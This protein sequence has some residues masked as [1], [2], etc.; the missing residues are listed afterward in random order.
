[1]TL[2]TER[3]SREPAAGAARE[4]AGRAL[5]HGRGAT[6]ATARPSSRWA[7]R[8]ALAQRWAGRQRPLYRGRRP[9]LERRRRL[10]RQR[11]EGAAAAA[12]VGDPRARRL[13]RDPPGTDR[14]R[15][16]R[17]LDHDGARARADRNRDR[18]LARLHR[19]APEHHA[20]VGGA[21]RVP[22]RRGSATELPQPDAQPRRRARRGRR[23]RAAQTP[24]VANVRFALEAGEALGIIGPSGAGKTSLVRALV[25][26]WPA[27]QGTR[28]ARRRRARPVG[29]GAAR[30]AYRLRLAD[31]RAVRRHHRREHR[32]HGRRA[33]C[34][35]RAARGARPPARTT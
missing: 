5:G 24:I 8:G 28:A 7:W 23:A 34:R 9:A 29:A 1:M 3:A 15:H 6:A 17:R 11:L 33:G 30:P 25:G 22:R 13:S 35:C 2:L 27:G 32:P 26:I 16:D 10:L 12:A 18:Q 21:A 4:D 19:R 31:G 14:R 20:A